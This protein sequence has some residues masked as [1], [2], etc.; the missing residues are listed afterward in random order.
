MNTGH[1]S[2]ACDSCH[3]PADGTIRQQ[4]QANVK[5]WLGM[6]KTEADFG[7]KDVGNADC[8]QCHERPFDRHPVFRF[9]EPRFR[10]ARQ[11]IA[12]QNCVSCHREH[13]DVRVTARSGYCVECHS[14]LELKNDPIDVSHVDLAR[15]QRWQTCL[16]CHDFHGN[17]VMDTPKRLSD[18][19][20]LA[21]L[22]RYFAGGKSPYPNELRARARKERLD[23]ASVQ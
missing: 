19:H 20:S 12:P 3:R 23:V 16:G 10:E 22:D 4:L 2:L 1:E 7:N 15:Q 6:R 18:A 11:A 13:S 21:E 8:L 5:Y 14:D 17:H 9:N